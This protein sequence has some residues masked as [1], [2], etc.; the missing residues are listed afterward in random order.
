MLAL[1]NNTTGFF[2]MANGFDALFSN[3]TGSYN[4]ATVLALF[5]N[6]TGNSNTAV[7][8][9]ALL[10][11]PPAPATLPWALRRLQSHHRQ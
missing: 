7:G 8:L 10:T 2:N 3:T 9:S 4:T 11:T 1:F 6:T 5:L